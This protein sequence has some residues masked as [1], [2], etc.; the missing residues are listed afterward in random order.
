[1]PAIVSINWMNTYRLI[2]WNVTCIPSSYCIAT[3]SNG[4]RYAGPFAWCDCAQRPAALL[5]C[6]RRIWWQTM[7]HR[8][9]ANSAILEW[10]SISIR[11]AID[12]WR[13]RVLRVCDLLPAI[14]IKSLK[15]KFFTHRCSGSKPMSSG[16]I[17]RMD[18]NCHYIKSTV[19]SIRFYSVTV[20]LNSLSR[21]KLR[22]KQK[23]FLCLVNFSCY[24]SFRT[25]PFNFLQMRG[26]RKSFGSIESGFM[27]TAGACAGFCMLKNDFMLDTSESYELSANERPFDAKRQAAIH[28]AY[29]SSCEIERVWAL[30]NSFDCIRTPIFHVTYRIAADPH[31]TIRTY[32]IIWRNL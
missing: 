24:R 7:W 8:I 13:L 11:S 21:L 32:T 20:W 5:F 1:M 14:Q 26:E 6:G 12:L 15:I 23:L 29:W 2:E 22:P 25:F 27:L 9:R 10:I 18:P 31:F 16:L 17:E 3:S 28:L 4:H 30:I 19:N